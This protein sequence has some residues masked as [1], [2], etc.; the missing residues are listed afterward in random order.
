V[1]LFDEQTF[2]PQETKTLPMRFTINPKLP[3]EYKTITLSYTYFDNTERSVKNKRGKVMS[4]NIAY[5]IPHKATWPIIGTIGLMI[6]LAGF[7]NYLNGSSIGPT[8]MVLG[9][10]F[11]LLC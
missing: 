8:M 2:K 3:K 5:Y 9:Y 10:L 4:T 7:A 1:F 11:L 6:M